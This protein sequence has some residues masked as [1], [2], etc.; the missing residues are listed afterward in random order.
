CSLTSHLVCPFKSTLTIYCLKDI[1]A[2]VANNNVFERVHLEQP[3]E[4]HDEKE[5]S[6]D[7][8]LTV[9]GSGLVYFASFGFINS[10][11]FFQDF[12]QSNFLSDYAPSKIAF[13]GTLQVTLMYLIGPVAG[14]LFDAFGLKVPF[15]WC[16]IGA[17]L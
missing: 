3:T 12:Y 14:A 11:G 9:A 13:I 6:V 8:W 1:M 10:F 7:A 4:S 17:K 5:G 2:T 15:I 16:K